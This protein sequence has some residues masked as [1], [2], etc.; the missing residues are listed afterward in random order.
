MVK[1][2]RREREVA[3]LVAEEL[4]NRAI[5]NRLFISKRTAEY[6]VE[7]ILNKLGFHSRTQVAAW[8]RESEQA[9]RGRIRG[10]NLPVQLTSFVGRDKE[11]AEL[12]VLLG[13]RR[14]VTLTGPAG[15]GKTRLA[16]KLAAQLPWPDGAWFIDLASVHDPGQVWDAIATS[17]QVPVPLG[18]EP[19]GVVGS[20]FATRSSLLIMDNSE[21]VV[22]AAAQ[23]VTELL[24]RCQNVR[25]LATSR[26]PLGVSGEATW[27]VAGLPVPAVTDE[28]LDQIKSNDAA[29]LF[30]ERAQLARPGFAV[31]EGNAGGVAEITRRLDGLPLAIELAAARIRT[32]SPAEVKERLSD[33]FRLLTGGGRG[34]LQR[35]QTLRAALE[36]SYTLLDP[37]ERTV[38]DRLGV[39]T[40]SFGLEAAEQVCCDRSLP[41]DRV[42]DLLCR[43]VEK[44][45]VQ[46]LETPFGSRYRLLETMRDFALDRALQSGGLADVRGR[47][48]AYFLAYAERAAPMLKGYAQRYWLDRLEEDHENLRAAHQWLREESPEACLR[49]ADALPCFWLRCNHLAEGRTLATE[50]LH[51]SSEPSRAQGWVLWTLSQLDFTRGDAEAARAHAEQALSTLRS[52]GDLAGLCCALSWSAMPVLAGCDAALA[53]QRREEAVQVGRASGDEYALSIALLGMGTAL[54]GLEKPHEA[55]GYIEEALTCTRSIGHGFNTVNCLDSLAGALHANGEV[56]DAAK[57]WAEALQIS[58]SLRDPAGTADCCYGFSRICLESDPARSLRL[59][60]AASAILHGSGA[61]RSS[62]DEHMLERLYAAGSEVLGQEAAEAAWDEGVVM[63][64]DEATAYALQEPLLKKA[65]AS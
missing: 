23:A 37:D 26:E 48:A 65:A 57:H 34:N 8:V 2:S 50:A 27:T 59:A 43:L 11:M 49:L 10:G 45:M 20:H 29:R 31:D 6:H 52:E 46:H 25:V 12:R 54:I 21:H 32:M 51:V 19:S 42:W 63:S 22:T 5:A 40:G 61:V 15:V 9:G 17:L 44:S 60:G 33:R 24:C 38:F 28:G 18:S 56:A 62:V 7:Q 47:H 3:G 14:L 13:Q 64:Q 1:L 58:A 41:P 30:V 53:A 35:H 16:L 39:F 4:S 55:M 36:W